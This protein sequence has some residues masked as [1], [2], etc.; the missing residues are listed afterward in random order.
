MPRHDDTARL[1][2]TVAPVPEV[3]MD[4]WFQWTMKVIVRVAQ[5]S[6]IFQAAAVPLLKLR[7]ST[8]EE[9]ALGFAEPYNRVSATIEAESYAIPYGEIGEE[10]SASRKLQTAALIVGTRPSDIN[11]YA[12]Q[13]FKKSIP[14]VTFY[15]NGLPALQ[16]AISISQNNLDPLPTTMS[17]V[18]SPLQYALL[19][20]FGSINY[21]SPLSNMAYTIYGDDVAGREGSNIVFNDT[22]AVV[23]KEG[24]LLIYDF[25][26]TTPTPIANATLINSTTYNFSPSGSV[27][28][29]KGDFLH[30]SGMVGSSGAYGIYDVLNR[31]RFNLK[32]VFLVNEPIYRIIISNFTLLQTPTRVIAVNTSDV[33]ALN[34]LFQL[35]YSTGSLYS[36]DLLV[37]ANNVLLAIASAGS[38]TIYSLTQNPLSPTVLCTASTP[39]PTTHSIAFYNASLFFRSAQLS[40]SSSYGLDAVR[41]VDNTTMILSSTFQLDAD[42]QSYYKRSIKI[43][44]DD[45]G[46]RLYYIGTNTYVYDISNPINPRLLTEFIISHLFPSIPYSAQYELTRYFVSNNRLIYS[47][48]VASG[49]YMGVIY[50]DDITAFGTLNG[51]LGLGDRTLT[52][53]I[54]MDA[55]Y[56]NSASVVR[57][58]V[59]A[60]VNKPQLVGSIPLATQSYIGI[61]AQRYLSLTTAVRNLDGDPETYHILVDGVD[62][63]S[64]I[65]ADL[66]LIPQSDFNITLWKSDNP[67]NARLVLN[68]NNTFLIHAPHPIA[69][70]TQFFNLTDIDAHVL[71]SYNLSDLSIPSYMLPTIIPLDQDRMIFNYYGNSAGVNHGNISILSRK[72]SYYENNFDLRQFTISGMVACR[73]QLYWV[74]SSGLGSALYN[75]GSLSVSQADCVSTG[76]VAFYNNYFIQ[77]F[78]FAY[79]FYSL[80]GNTFSGQYN[81]GLS[82]LGVIKQVG[83]YLVCAQSQRGFFLLD[84]SPLPAATLVSQLSIANIGLVYD[85]FIPSEDKNL[86]FMA[87]DGGLLIF[88]ISYPTLPLQLQQLTL[89]GT[90][91]SVVVTGSMALISL[92]DGRIFQL[93]APGGSWRNTHILS[94]TAQ[95]HSRG[96][97]RVT[98]RVTNPFGDFYDYSTPWTVLNRQPKINTTI[99]AS[100]N[101]VLIAETSVPANLKSPAGIVYDEDEGDV[102]TP[103]GL[104][105]V[106]GVWQNPPTPSIGFFPPPDSTSSAMFAADFLPVQT[107]IYPV[108]FCFSDGVAMICVNGTIINPNRAP[109]ASRG[110]ANTTMTAGTGVVSGSSVWRDANSDTM[111]FNVTAS[112][113][114]VVVSADPITGDVLVITKARGQGLSRYVVVADDGHGGIGTTQAYVVYQ[115]TAPVIPV[116]SLSDALVGEDWSYVFAPPVDVDDDVLTESFTGL[117]PGFTY[118]T[119]TLRLTGRASSAQVGTVPITRRVFDGYVTSIQPYF[120]SI[121][122]TLDVAVGVQ[123]LTYTEGQN[124]VFGS[125]TNIVIT[126]SAISPTNVLVLLTYDPTAGLVSA[127]TT[128][129][130][131]IDNSQS[132]TLV[133]TG[134]PAQ[135]NQCLQSLSFA[136]ARFYNRPI[137]VNILVSYGANT[138]QS[139]SLSFTGAAVGDPLTPPLQSITPISVTPLRPTFGTITAFGNPDGNGL[140]YTADILAANGAVVVSSANAANAWGLSVNQV[141]GSFSFTAPRDS[142]AVYTLRVT[143]QALDSFNNP[144]VGKTNSTSTTL[145][146]SN[147][148]PLIT[149]ETL[150]GG[151][152]GQSYSTTLLSPSDADD[153]FL[154]DRFTNLPPSLSYNATTRILSGTLSSSMVGTVPLIREVSDGFIVVQQTYFLSSVK[155]L[156]LSIGQQSFTYTEDVPLSF[157]ATADIRVSGSGISPR[158]ITVY[159]TNAVPESALLQVN[160]TTGVVVDNSQSGTFILRGLA[161][162]LNTC[163]QTLSLV[164]TPYYDNPINL[165]ILVVDGL[166]V[167]VSNSFSF[168]GAHVEHA[169]TAPTLAMASVSTVPLQIATGTIPAFGNPDRNSL[170]YSIDILNS[171]GTVVANSTV[172]GDWTIQINQQ[173]GTYAIISPPETQGT[174]LLRAHVQALNGAGVPIP[175]KTGSISTVLTV[176]NIAPTLLGS[177][178]DQL[179][180]VGHNFTIP[181]PTATSSVGN[182]IT[183][184][185]ETSTGG[186]A[187]AGIQIVRSAS[188]LLFLSGTVPLDAPPSYNLVVIYDDAKGGVVRSS[189]TATNKVGLTARN[190][191]DNFMQNAADISLS[192]MEVTY[193]GTQPITITVKVP[194]Q[195]G[196]PDVSMVLTAVRPS[197][198]YDSLLNQYVWQI[199]GTQAEVN[200]YLKNIRLDL[201]ENSPG[202][203]TLEVDYNNGVDPLVTHYKTVNVIH[204]NQAPVVGIPF[205]DTTVEANEKINLQVVTV[206]AFDDPDLRGNFGEHLSVYNNGTVPG[207]T[208]DA[209]TQTYVGTVAAP[210]TIRLMPCVRD[211]GGLSVCNPAF[212]TIVPKPILPFYQSFWDANQK[213]FQYAGYVAAA[214]PAAYE[215]MLFVKFLIDRCVS[216]RRSKK[217]TQATKAYIEKLK[218]IEHTPREY[219]VATDGIGADDLE[220]GIREILNRVSDIIQRDG[221]DPNFEEFINLVDQFDE[222]VSISLLTGSSGKLQ[223]MV[224]KALKLVG[225]HI[226]DAFMIRDYGDVTFWLAKLNLSLIE[227]YFSIT[228][229]KGYTIKVAKQI[230]LINLILESN[231]RSSVSSKIASYIF[232]RLCCA[233]LCCPR[234]VKE[235]K[236]PDDIK[237]KIKAALAVVSRA[238]TDVTLVGVIRALAQPAPPRGTNLAPAASPWADQLMRLRAQSVFALHYRKDLLSMVKDYMQVPDENPHVYARY[239]D[240]LNS[241]LDG[242]KIRLESLT[243][244]IANLEARGD[245]SA[246]ILTEISAKKES[247]IESK[248]MMG[249]ISESIKLR[250]NLKYIM[251]KANRELLAAAILAYKTQLK[252]DMLAMYN[253]FFKAIAEN[254]R[255]VEF[256]TMATTALRE[257]RVSKED[258]PKP[259]IM[260]VMKFYICPPPRRAQAKVRKTLRTGSDGS[261]PSVFNENPLRAGKSVKEVAVV[262]LR[263]KPSRRKMEVEKTAVAARASFSDGYRSPALMRSRV[264]VFG[265]RG[266]AVGNAGGTGLRV[267]SAT[268]PAPVRRAGGAVASASTKRATYLSSD[269]ERSADSAATAAARAAL[270]RDEPL[271]ELPE[272]S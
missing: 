217:Q 33:A 3:V 184:R 62:A 69:S 24:K 90:P 132:G 249:L 211:A 198:S 84:I 67:P 10:K 187:P 259:S 212:Y 107:G 152:V 228:T 46:D 215:I 158:I 117:P 226:Q 221:I 185:V 22:D 85:L 267:L 140:F 51:K 16:A 12:N 66:K 205:A 188:G 203:F 180:S 44:R 14:H 224:L 260:R 116:E 109:V 173:L 115:N 219:F 150:P 74:P 189:F 80:P 142:Q 43:I 39:S 79:L 148:A 227:Y 65:S 23:A 120:L 36:M 225:K 99:L 161:A 192:S 125:L 98:V 28:E 234:R 157:G 208:W 54:K 239:T 175:F 186:A 136:P 30:A 197:L 9:A 35:S 164:P 195:L 254:C 52:T 230:Q 144:I 50:S 88:D 207:I 193:D 92:S 68:Y 37:D 108:Q 73:N 56:N 102:L 241:L 32:G 60:L 129:G 34:L 89:P 209:I 1:R 179:L 264:V 82:Q 81:L 139:F 213:Y 243:T 270:E 127:A 170:R 196:A 87:C 93:M 45:H 174:Y 141:A 123:S 147:T 220:T 95:A 231:V 165:N 153:D 31:T 206:T 143:A 145:S 202:T 20:P 262:T 64:S 96:P 194:K 178:P 2:G 168:I 167:P 77:N 15:L 105:F 29:R 106:N 199:T 58:N 237:L 240:T 48:M 229:A 252:P 216:N 133:L 204:V 238:E 138:P 4:S 11:V 113:P 6:T 18:P 247:L 210:G 49:E 128:S 97:H 124:A 245:T 232:Y 134:L 183:V 250:E 214:T 156:D 71:A 160:A 255:L 121:K 41:I 236:T 182:S 94:G 13:V 130:V 78:G 268:T 258:L 246:G 261:S 114:G 75:L 176:G 218:A 21:Y 119:T 263:S 191:V 111:F 40:G 159:I 162:D 149:A 122:K 86:V 265:G 233:R 59:N 172:P 181:I 163:L 177:I 222:R 223:G 42:A 91:T 104:I 235:D 103:S 269:D 244:E 248:A 169:I 171:N 70:V 118:N 7:G 8:T 271:V 26:T 47:V 166:N 146:V 190:T 272:Y 55:S 38:D 27:I 201:T 154:I 112:G 76:Q 101:T 110:Y 137:S 63:V 266:A 242:I 19:P 257:K 53:I 83:T 131:S 5:V 200:P 126:G 135:V 25:S 256:R 17:W 57:I 253:S 61:S 72:G 100:W 251:N 151:E 155:S